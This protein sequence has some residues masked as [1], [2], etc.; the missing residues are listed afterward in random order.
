[1]IAGE[2]EDYKA[3]LE[4][5][6]RSFKMCQS[7]L[8]EASDRVNELS[9]QNSSLNAHKK[10]LETTVQQMQSDLEAQVRGNDTLSIGCKQTCVP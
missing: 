4:Q 5:V 10:R 3:Q 2:V 1:M 6:E 9:A 7:E 8:N